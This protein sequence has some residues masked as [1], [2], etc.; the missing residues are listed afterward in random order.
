MANV[1]ARNDWSAKDMAPN[2]VG[3]D[4]RIRDE[5]ANAWEHTA[6]MEHASI[7]AFA[8]FSL[9]LLS[10]GAPSDLIERTNAA[11]VD[12]TKHARVAFAMVS[13]YRGK[14]TGPGRLPTARAMDDSDDVCSILRRVIREGCIGE[15]VAAV[16][17]GEA[18]AGAIDAVVGQTLGMIASD[19]SEHAELAWRT[20]KWALETFGADVRKVVRD[21]IVLLSNELATVHEIRRTE[22]D[23]TLLRHGVV[24]SEVRGTIRRATIGQVV[25]PCLEGLLQATARELQHADLSATA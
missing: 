25:V 21:E 19:E 24:T 10:L 16:E 8:R 23:E 3:L 13:V 15:T 18:S 6:R 11:M 14:P 9:E 12:E 1:A 20:V 17:A 4:E 22:R 7:A 5:L 2:L